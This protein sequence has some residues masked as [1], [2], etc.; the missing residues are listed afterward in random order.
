MQRYI[1]IL[2]IPNVLVFFLKRE[3]WDYLVMG[4][5]QG[6]T[7]TYLLFIKGGMGT[8]FSLGLHGCFLPKFEYCGGEEI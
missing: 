1:I 4:K 3:G 7:D 5:G 6:V 8:C 2:K